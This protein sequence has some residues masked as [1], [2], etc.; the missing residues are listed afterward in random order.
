M[1]WVFL[2]STFTKHLLHTFFIKLPIRL[3]TKLWA[4]VSITDRQHHLTH[5]IIRGDQF[6]G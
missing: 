3:S 2:L 4:R 1:E 6:M 5:R